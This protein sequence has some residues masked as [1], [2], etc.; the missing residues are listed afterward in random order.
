MKLDY[1]IDD[2]FKEQLEGLRPDASHLTYSNLVEQIGAKVGS[3]TALSQSSGFMAKLGI[4]KGTFTLITVGVVSVSSLVL[5][6]GSE[7][8]DDYEADFLALNQLTELNEKRTINSVDLPVDTHIEIVNHQ[9]AMVIGEDKTDLTQNDSQNNTELDINLTEE[10][11]NTLKTTQTRQ[12]KKIPKSRVYLPAESEPDTKQKQVSQHSS[13][14]NQS[15]AIAKPNETKPSNPDEKTNSTPVTTDINKTNS[16]QDNPK[17]VET[18]ELHDQSNSFSTNDES[19]AI[20]E[21]SESHTP[22]R[23]LLKPTDLI[24]STDTVLPVQEDETIPETDDT[25]TVEG[26]TGQDTTEILLAEEQ[27]EFETDSN[28][29]IQ[30]TTLQSGGIPIQPLTKQQYPKHQ[31]ILKSGLLKVPVNQPEPL[32]ADPS[33]IPPFMVQSFVSEHAADNE[34]ASA[35]EYQYSSNNMILGAG[36]NYLSGSWNTKITGTASVLIFDTIGNTFVVTDT[37]NLGAW[38][39]TY[40]TIGLSLHAGYGYSFNNFDLAGTVGIIGQQIKS[41][42]I[43]TD[44][45]IEFNNQTTYNYSGLA[46]STY[47]SLDLTYRIKKV[48]IS[49]G[50][51]IQGRSSLSEVIKAEQFYDNSAFGVN[52]GLHYYFSGK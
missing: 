33:M 20:K 35:L 47:A 37:I 11:S 10:K 31:I 51:T 45:S 4:L 36:M 9:K 5:F 16:A 48:G 24:A 29:V 52:A 13:N 25:E 6:S 39:T 26:S 8:L 2:L 38:N 50:G 46:I 28:T 42:N 17:I 41:E 18:P 15:L 34:W 32:S 44:Q 1:D 21:N 27:T 23:T 19:I 40:Q 49:V 14:T 12:T 3:E 22:D 43:Y 30:D 7:K